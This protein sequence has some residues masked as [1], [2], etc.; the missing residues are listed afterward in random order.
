MKQKTNLPNGWQGV[1]LGTI[2]KILTGFAFKSSL[3]NK[4]GKGKPLIRIRDLFDGKSETYYSGE[5]EDKYLVQRGDFL[6]GMDGEFKIFEWRSEDALLNQRV[7]KIVLN[8]ELVFPKYI[9]YMISKKLK[10]IEDKTPFVTVKHISN[11][12]I[13]KISFILPPIQVQ[14]K[15]VSILEKAQRLKQ[16]R[17]ESDEKTN[18]Y[19]K[20][21][22]YE[23][24]FI[25]KFD[26][27][28]INLGVIE[29][30]N[31]NPAKDSP[32]EYFNYIDIASIDNVPK[33]I[34]ETKEILGKDA[35]SRAKQLIKYKDIL[36]S[37]VRPNLN[38]V[39][40]VPEKLNN[41]IC[42]TGFCIL[43]ADIKKFNP[44]YLYF[45]SQSKFFI[46]LLVKKCKGANYPAVSNNDILSIEIPLPPLP[47][48]Q[49]F[50]KIVEKV[51]KLKEKQRE[52]KD[53]INELFDVL[54]QKAFRGEL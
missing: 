25:E 33:K 54:M 14:K 45:I 19:L 26:K 10:D 6:I 34:M 29:T 31:K 16:K 7:C 37:T 47:L 20:S 48:Q 53:K 38:A 32:G 12:Q 44:E 46:D 39:A 51:E 52:S 15:I 36:I 1:E 8:K 21:I 40:M 41:Q 9:F 50:T 35:P 24:F 4:E 28:R 23:M 27:I 43:R 49:K 30:E 3:F 5:Y 13:E 18:E 11:K 17:E 2:C 22:F 42:S